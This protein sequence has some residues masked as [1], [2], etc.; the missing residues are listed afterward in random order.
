[1]QR[2]VLLLAGLLVAVAVDITTNVV[3]R[4]QTLQALVV[5]LVVEEEEL[6]RTIEFKL[7]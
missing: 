4:Q 2:G 6:V 5:L 1:L 3:K 7:L